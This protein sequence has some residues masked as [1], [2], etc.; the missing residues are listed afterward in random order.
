MV[1]NQTKKNYATNVGAFAALIV[2]VAFVLISPWVLIEQ[3]S[4]V[5]GIVDTLLLLVGLLGSVL[6]IRLLRPVGW[7]GIF[8]FFPA[9][10]FAVPDLDHASPAL[11][12]FPTFWRVGTTALLCLALLFSFKQLAPGRL[13]K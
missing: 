12:G 4:L 3:T 10:L 6:R 11:Q 7:L 1:I 13:D 9:V 8:L 2:M 5:Y